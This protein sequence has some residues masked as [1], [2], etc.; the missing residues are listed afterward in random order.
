[1]GFT[2]TWF[3]IIGIVLISVLVAVLLVMLIAYIVYRQTL[4]WV[5]RTHQYK[6]IKRLNGLSVKIAS[7][8]EKQIKDLERVISAFTNPKPKPSMESES[9]TF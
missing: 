2:C 8:D 9:V 6:S 4:E 3:D 1:M 7:L 5:Q